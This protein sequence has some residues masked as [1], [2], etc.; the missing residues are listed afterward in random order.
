MTE[1]PERRHADF[2]DFSRLMVHLPT[3]QSREKL[4]AQEI[5]NTFRCVYGGSTYTNLTIQPFVGAWLDNKVVPPV[6]YEG[7]VALLLIDVP[8]CITTQSG[9][10]GYDVDSLRHYVLRTY[11][12][13]LVPQMSVW[14]T[15]APIVIRMP[16]T[17]ADLGAANG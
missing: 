17:D 5:I 10:R 1:A 3:Y 15:I 16:T 13:F 9:D 7:S 8:R 6:L 11:N 4:A 14:I 2:H 12:E